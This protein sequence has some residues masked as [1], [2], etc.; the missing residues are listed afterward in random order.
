MKEFVID[1]FCGAGGTSEGVHLA[2]CDSVVTACVNH[3]YNAIQSHR[4]NHPNA[5]HFIE[6]IRNPEVVFFLKLR[7]DALRKKH[8]T[9]RVWADGKMMYNFS[10][11]DL[12]EG[13]G[14]FMLS[15]KVKDVDGKEVY[16]GDILYDRADDPEAPNGKYH[17]SYLPVFF[18]KGCF[19][20]DESFNLDRSSKCLLI[21]FGDLKVAGNVFENSELIIKQGAP[22]LEH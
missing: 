15:S 22:G 16:D 9:M 3:D 6:D 13:V 12:I 8:P 17:E 20:V 1:L 10:L 11:V 2:N 7:V 19:W 14:L 21:E 4:K 5:K 18:E